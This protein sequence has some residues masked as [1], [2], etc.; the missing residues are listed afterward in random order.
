MTARTVESSEPI[1][2]T[3]GSRVASFYPSRIATNA[4]T[5][6]RR[7]VPMFIPAG[8]AYYWS[9]VWQHGEA[10]TKANLKAGNARTFDDPLDAVR[11]LL[12]DC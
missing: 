5:R 10:E 12:D 1:F 7:Q 6:R 11:H 3:R 9:G 4:K 8:Q 2:R